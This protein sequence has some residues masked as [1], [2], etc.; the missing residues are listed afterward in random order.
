MIYIQQP[1][2]SYGQPVYP[3]DAGRKRIV[4]KTGFAY[5]R[6][7]KYNNDLFPLQ[8]GKQS[9]GFIFPAH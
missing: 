9:L 1:G 2:Y 7:S 5:A 8:Q 6:F 4:Y 3:V